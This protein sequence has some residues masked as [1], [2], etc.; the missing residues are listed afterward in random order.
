MYVWFQPRSVDYQRRQWPAAL[1]TADAHD[2]ARFHP[3]PPKTTR[4]RSMGSTN[5]KQKVDKLFK[6]SSSM[7]DEI[8]SI[9]ALESCLLGSSRM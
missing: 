7:V 6:G 9:T 5:Q 4:K 8:I 2:L 3:K 1:F